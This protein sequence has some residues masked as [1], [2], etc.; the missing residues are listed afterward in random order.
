VAIDD[1]D[2]VKELHCV[3]ASIVQ[4]IRR[5]RNDEQPVGRNKDT[6]ADR[7]L[8]AADRVV[9]NLPIAEIDVDWVGV[10]QLD[11]FGAAAWPRHEF[12]DQYILG[13][14]SMCNDSIAQQDYTEHQAYDD[15]KP[16]SGTKQHGYFLVASIYNVYRV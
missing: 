10:E 6:S 14:R 4:D 11:P 12:V 5:Q 2:R 16:A 1:A 9:V 3:R 7:R 15:R 8:Y 13:W